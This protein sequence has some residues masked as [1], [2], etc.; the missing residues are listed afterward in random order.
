MVRVTPG[1]D[2]NETDELALAE[3]GGYA[4]RDALFWLTIKGGTITRIEQQWVP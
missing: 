2:P 1:G 3:F 4:Q